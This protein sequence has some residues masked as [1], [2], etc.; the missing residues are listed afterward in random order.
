LVESRVAAKKR[1]PMP[2]SPPEAPSPFTVCLTGGI[3]SG[4]STVARLF[5]TRGIFVIDADA[6]AHE[7][8]APGGGAIAPIRAAFGDDFIDAS[9]ALDRGRMRALAFERPEARARLEGILH[10]M[11]RV[12]AELLAAAASSAYVIQMIPLLF[13]SGRG[14]GRCSRIL[15]VDCTEEIQIHRVMARS[16]LPREQVEAIMAAQVSRAQRLAGADDVVDN[17]GPPGALDARVAE[18]HALYLRLAGGADPRATR[19]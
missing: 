19:R 9:G 12:A 3:G 7:L 8:T 14:R 1:D 13:E 10:P 18:L 5:E 15:V 4:K 2:E 11:I 17:S 6:L 16:R